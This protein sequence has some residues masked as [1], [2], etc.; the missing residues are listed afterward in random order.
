MDGGW[1]DQEVFTSFSS[2]LIDLLIIRRVNLVLKNR[3]LAQS[4]G[5]YFFRDYKYDP[6]VPGH[7]KIIATES[8]ICVSVIANCPWSP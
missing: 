2:K 3:M 4:Q 8:L 6:D 7:L 1:N 5:I